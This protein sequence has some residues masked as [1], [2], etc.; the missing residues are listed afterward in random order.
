MPRVAL[1]CTYIYTT[2]TCK[3][4]NRCPQ[5]TRLLSTDYEYVVCRNVKLYIYCRWYVLLHILTTAIMSS[6]ARTSSNGKWLTRLL[7]REGVPHESLGPRYGLTQ[8]QTDRLTVGRNMTLTW[9]WPWHETESVSESVSQSVRVESESRIL[10]QKR[11]RLMLDD[12]QAA[13]TCARKQRNF[14][15][16]KTLESRAVKTVTESTTVC[17]IVVCKA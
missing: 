13:R 1:Y 8:R 11:R 6:L 14:H 2:V 3:T 12:S 16:W 17:V 4:V 10:R 7:V 15:C 5:E 9:L